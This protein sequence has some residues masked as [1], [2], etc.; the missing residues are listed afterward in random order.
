M[1]KIVTVAEMVAAEKAADRGGHSYADMMDLAG[2]A[3]AERILQALPFGGRVPQVVILVGRGNNGGD[4]LVAARYLKLALPQTQ[5]SC[6]LL[7]VRNDEVFCAARDAGVVMAYLPNDPQ[8]SILRNLV[9]VADVL[10][11]ALFG[12]GVR[13]PL[14]QEPAMLLGAVRGALQR[15]RRATPRTDAPTADPKAVSVFML[16]NLLESLPLND[17]P[18]PYM[19]AVDCPS[20]LDCDTGAIDDNTLAV[21]ETVTFAAAK[22][23]HFAF[24]GAEFCGRLHIAPI[25]IPPELLEGVRLEVLDKPGVQAM[26]PKRRAD[27]HKGSY[28]KALIVAGSPSFVGAAALAG[29]ACARVGAGLVRLAIPQGIH[30]PLAAQLPEVVWTV[31]PDTLGAAAADALRGDLGGQ[32]ALLVGC[33]L[34]ASAGSRALLEE[35]LKIAPLPPLVIDADGL[36]VLAMLPDWAGR[37]PKKTILTPH[38]REFARLAGL[39]SAEQVQANRLG[40][41]QEKA[42][43]W[44]AVVVLKGAYTVIA[45]PDGSTYVSPFASAKLATAGTG[46][47]LAGVI[48]GLLAQG[49]PPFYAAAAGV[50][51]HGWAGM[52]GTAAAGVVAGDVLRG[53]SAAM[54]AV[55]LT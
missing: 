47:V 27:S 52:F 28:G 24:P 18:Y 9:G 4:G 1:A 20:G 13:L 23:G 36:N 49:L 35:L 53:L 33:G 50:W 10:V 29:G 34:G 55:I 22:P 42:A 32:D 26:L 14:R 15:R 3:V 40:L 7:A 46:D 44:G 38:P 8:F 37:I 6:Y 16:D 30:T 48:T 51:L 11:D 17:P 54:A 31:L 21:D 43:A 45:A 5:V 2:A 25:G 12:T 41:A 19:I 39:D